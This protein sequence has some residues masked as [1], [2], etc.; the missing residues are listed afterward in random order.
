MNHEQLIKKWLDYA[1]ADME[2]ADVLAKNPKSS[3]S[4][5]LAVW[6]CHQAI[7]KILKTVIVNNKG[8]A[9]KI[10]D[11]VR[12]AELSK[13]KLP[14]EFQDYIRRLNAHYIL[15]RYPD[16]RHKGP[17]LKYNQTTADEHLKE[18]K[19]LFLW[20]IKELKSKK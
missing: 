5:Q 3:W 1:K 6:H 13:L 12:L 11:L 7:E 17:I 16:I 2:A 9:Y 15:P 4:Y 8:E 10:H 18:T 19:R 20:I 14:P